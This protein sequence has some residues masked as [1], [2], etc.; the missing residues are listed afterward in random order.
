MLKSSI[1]TFGFWEG[2]KFYFINYLINMKLYLFWCEITKKKWCE[3]NG[4]ECKD[5]NCRFK[6]HDKP[7]RFCHAQLNFDGTNYFVSCDKFK[8]HHGNHRGFGFE[9][10][11]G[12]THC[13]NS[14]RLRHMNLFRMHIKNVLKTKSEEEI[15]D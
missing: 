6:H 2:I 15:H 12:T 14:Y 3:Q 7:R 13:H 5:K 4:Y 8:G 10:E 9:W 1:E 11:R